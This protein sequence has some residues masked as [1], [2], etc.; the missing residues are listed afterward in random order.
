M[1]VIDVS[2]SMTFADPTSNAMVSKWGVE[3]PVLSSTIDG[4]PP[5]FGI[6]VLY[7]PNKPTPPS[8]TMRPPSACINV[9]AMIGVDYLGMKGSRQRYAIQQS[10][11]ITEP[12]TQ[13]GTPTLDAYMVALQELGTV[14]LGGSRNIVLITDGQP[15]FA[16]GCV[17]TGDFDVPVDETP[18]I[19]AISQAKRA[20]ISTFV[21]GSP[22]SEQGYMTGVDARPWLSRAAQAGGT[23]RPGCSNDGPKYCHLDMV[24]EPNFGAGLTAALDTI[25][26][27]VG[28]CGVSLPA[29][30][31]NRRLDPNQVNIILTTGD[32]RETLVPHDESSACASGEG[33]QYSSDRGRITLCAETCQRLRADE[34]AQIEVLAGCASGQDNLPPMR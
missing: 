4:F 22:G 15:T 9:G 28:R 18:I 20:G 17:G 6:G 16:E 11:A 26:G 2:G 25:G 7:Y 33:W 27:S 31:P 24:E 10:L 1:M 32:G 23:A 14:T 13:E 30:P 8:T 29:A 3:R 21:I 19:D 34:G 5:S 12:T